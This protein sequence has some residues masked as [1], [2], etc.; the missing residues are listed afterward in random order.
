M[1][2]V[3]VFVYRYCVY[4]HICAYHLDILSLSLSLYLSLSL[5]L[6][7]YMCVYI[8]IYIYIYIYTHTYVSLL[9]TP[10]TER[11]ERP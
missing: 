10:P 4:M 3:C 7:M 2:R 11:A 8:H 9:V 1:L 6:Y 5:S